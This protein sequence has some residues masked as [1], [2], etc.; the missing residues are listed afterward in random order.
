MDLRFLVFVHQLRM[1][2][3][4]R[5]AQTITDDIGRIDLDSRTDTTGDLVSCEATYLVQADA[6]S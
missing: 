1:F 4:D 3:I 6:W 5:N 2:E